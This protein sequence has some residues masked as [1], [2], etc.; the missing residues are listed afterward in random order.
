LQT[1]E[2]QLDRKDEQIGALNERMRESNI[3]MKEL[4]EKVAIAAPLT[5]PHDGE[6]VVTDDDSKPKEESKTMISSNRKS[7]SAKLSIWKRQFHL[8]GNK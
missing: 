3:L 6:V 5:K 7:A 4:Q 2:T 1:L 8:F